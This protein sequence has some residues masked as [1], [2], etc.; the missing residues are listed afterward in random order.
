MVIAAFVVKNKQND[1]FLKIAAISLFFD[2]IF[3]IIFMPRDTATT[4][5]LK[6]H[7]SFMDCSYS[8]CGAFLI[9]V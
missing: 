4:Y 7:N 9:F 6:N 8:G 2:I 3:T 1:I 5:L